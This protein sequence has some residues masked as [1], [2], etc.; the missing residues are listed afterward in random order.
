MLSCT[1][2]LTEIEIKNQILKNNL[3]VASQTESVYR[4]V[5]I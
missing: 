3:L 2:L 5:N 1:L 4:F